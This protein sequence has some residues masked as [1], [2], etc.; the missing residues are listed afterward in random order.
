MSLES[1]GKEMS[2]LNTDIHTYI[3]TDIQTYIHTDRQTEPKYI[4]LLSFDY[5]FFGH[6]SSRVF[7]LLL[8]FVVSANVYN[9]IY[10]LILS[11]ISFDILKP[12]NL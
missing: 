7:L 9:Y 4:V 2:R 8:N 1:E 3:H 12:C 5:F 10:I 6:K 11:G